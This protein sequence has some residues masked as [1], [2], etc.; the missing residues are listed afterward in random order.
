MKEKL[1]EQ[2]FKR[3]WSERPLVLSLVI[4]MTF[5]IFI[6]LTPWDIWRCVKIFV[7]KYKHIKKLKRFLVLFSIKFLLILHPFFKGIAIWTF[8]SLIY[9]HLSANINHCFWYYPTFLVWE[10]MTPSLIVSIYNVNKAWGPLVP[11]PLPLGVEN[12]KILKIRGPPG[13]LRDPLQSFLGP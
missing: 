13:V 9:F 10:L 5:F 1:S 7:W 12:V 11:P 8:C 6:L 4:L 3:T 2:S